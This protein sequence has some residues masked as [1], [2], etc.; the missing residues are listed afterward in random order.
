M[1]SRKLFI[2]SLLGLCAM[3][4]PAQPQQR[5]VVLPQTEAK[6]LIGTEVLGLP[7]K[8]TGTWEPKQ[9]DVAG[10]E[11]SFHQISDLSRKGFSGRQVGDPARYFRQYLGLLQGDRKLIYLNAFCGFNNN[12]LAPK[13][14]REH[15]VVIYDGGSCVWRAI[16]DVSTK[17]FVSLSVNGFA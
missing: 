1:I 4:I 10:M 5:W 9:D 6:T 2:A 8:I 14:W 17:R 7:G 15:L 11:A 13:N 3:T 12:S 16:F